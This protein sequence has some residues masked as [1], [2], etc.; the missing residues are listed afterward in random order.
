[1]SFPLGPQPNSVFRRFPAARRAELQST[2]GFSSHSWE[3]SLPSAVTTTRIFASLEATALSKGQLV[4]RLPKKGTA[5]L[6]ADDHHVI[7]M[8]ARTSAQVITFGKS[9]DADVRATEV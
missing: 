5:I 4:E 7:A 8:A 2:A 3:S 9:L 6:N 1:M